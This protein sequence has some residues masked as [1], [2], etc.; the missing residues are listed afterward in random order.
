LLL[1]VVS[2]VAT[3]MDKEEYHFPSIQDRFLCAHL[4]KTP[5]YTLLEGTLEKAAKS[6]TAALRTLS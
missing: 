2:T 4:R 1:V 3:G 5:R 6:V